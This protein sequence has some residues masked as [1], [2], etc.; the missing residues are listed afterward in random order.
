M[1]RIEIIGASGVGKTTLYREMVKIKDAKDDWVSLEEA[2]LELINTVAPALVPIDRMLQAILKLK[3]F[4]QYHGFMIGRI[5]GQYDSQVFDAVHKNYDIIADAGLS[6]MQHNKEESSMKRL[7]LA[8]YLYKILIKDIMP[9]A[10][11]RNN[12]LILYDDGIIHNLSVFS[13]EVASV[14]IYDH[15]LQNETGIVPVGVIYCYTSLQENLRRRNI[16][17]SQNKGTVIERSLEDGILKDQCIESLRSASCKAQILQ[18]YGVE[19]KKIDTSESLR[20]NAEMA[21]TFIRDLHF[22]TMM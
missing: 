4:P 19:V 6:S 14:K 15:S 9:F 10:Y 21:T 11:F 12:A 22:N 20:K 3:I 16:R 2:K 8:S 7:A 17:I 5:L 13:D 18:S 1:R